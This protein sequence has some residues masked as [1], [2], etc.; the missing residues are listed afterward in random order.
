MLVSRHVLAAS[1][2]YAAPYYIVRGINPGPV[3]MITSGVHG[4]ETASMAAAQKLA[5]DCASG[6][7]VIHR[8]TL[9]IVPRVNQQAYAKKIR[10]KPDLNRTFPRRKSGKAKH[11]L[12]A[13]VF[14]L[15]RAHQPDW[16]LDLHEAN[17]LSQLSP[18]VLGQTL[19]TNPG[20]SSVPICRRVIERMNRSIPAHKH[21]FNLKRHELPGSARTAAARLLSAKSVTVETCWSLKR[22]VRIK[23]QTQIV[24]HFLREAGMS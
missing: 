1:S 6:R 3:M 5:D 9:I 18:R 15:A 17:G 21:H 7:Y 22:A 8:G 14:Q 23:Y 11:P 10:G 24:H 20:S 2:V 12:A 13:A 4:N 16:W 19:I